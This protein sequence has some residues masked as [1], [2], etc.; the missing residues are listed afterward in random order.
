MN[1][2]QPKPAHG[3]LGHL[4]PK[5]FRRG[6]YFNIRI[7]EGCLARQRIGKAKN[8]TPRHFRSPQKQNYN[9]AGNKRDWSDNKCVSNVSSGSQKY[10]PSSI[11]APLLPLINVP[12]LTYGDIAERHSVAS[13]LA[14]QR[15]RN[16]EYYPSIARGCARTIRQ[17][18][19]RPPNR[20]ST[21]EPEQEFYPSLQ[22]VVYDGRA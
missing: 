3:D 20:A 10:D 14:C 18:Q 17:E 9:L 19:P 21:G 2:L 11:L 22:S 12:V 16:L 1:T 8:S 13:S 15:F 4:D 6:K 5:I 7:R